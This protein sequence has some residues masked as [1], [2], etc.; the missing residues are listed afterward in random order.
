M[1]YSISNLFQTLS[2]YNPPI[3][4]AMFQAQQLEQPSELTAISSGNF[5]S[6]KMAHI[7]VAKGS[8]LQFFEYIDINTFAHVHS[9][10]THHEIDSL[11]VLDVNEFRLF[12]RFDAVLS[13]V[14]SQY[15]L[16]QSLCSYAQRILDSF[17]LD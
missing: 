8:S 17:I 11:V 10:E 1:F 2:S 12:L 13:L 7:V 15:A 4:L 14:F 9:F 5:F 3:S 6:R 16:L